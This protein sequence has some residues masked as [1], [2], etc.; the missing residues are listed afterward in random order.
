MEKKDDDAL[1]YLEV[2]FSETQAH[3]QLDKR[4]TQTTVLRGEVDYGPP[5]VFTR[6]AE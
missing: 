1:A 3:P 2:L 6:G 4:K 5:I